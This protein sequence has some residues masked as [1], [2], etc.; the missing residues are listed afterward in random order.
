MEIL[1]EKAE[2][3][4]FDPSEYVLMD[5]IPGGLCFDSECSITYLA[6]LRQWLIEKH[7]LFVQVTCRNL[8]DW[9]ATIY[10]LEDD[11]YRCAPILFQDTGYSDNI[12]ALES[13]LLKA[14]DIL[15]G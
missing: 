10:L 3:M 12:E 11:P 2:M 4:G 7:C 1:R 9:G 8:G 14:M 15:E 6:M 5:D 13:G